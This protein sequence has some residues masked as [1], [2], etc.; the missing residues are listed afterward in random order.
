MQRGIKRFARPVF[1]AATVGVCAIG[2]TSTTTQVEARPPWPPYACPD[3][4]APVICSDGNIYS[5]GCYAS[6]Y[7]ATGCVPWGGD[8]F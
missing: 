4:Y 5:N 2:L 1:A 6:I 8:I 7:G 3:V